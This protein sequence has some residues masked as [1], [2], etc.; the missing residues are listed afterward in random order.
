MNV[1]CQC[2]PHSSFLDRDHKVGPPPADAGG[3]VT[4]LDEGR[5]PLS[6][7]ALLGEH[8]K[9]RTLLIIAVK[10]SR[11]VSMVDT[12]VDKVLLV[13][14]LATLLMLSCTQEVWTVGVLAAGVEVAVLPFSRVQK[15]VTD[16]VS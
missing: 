13:P 2:H 14:L 4:T 11:F 6:L 5:F 12:R 10:E 8:S 1:M 7:L 15:V 9:P 3:G 16:N